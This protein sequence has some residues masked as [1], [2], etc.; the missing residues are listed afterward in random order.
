M[1]TSKAKLEAWRAHWRDPEWQAKISTLVEDQTNNPFTHSQL[2]YW[3]SLEVWD[4]EEGLQILSGVEPGTVKLDLDDEPFGGPR[5]ADH[6]WLN[7]EPFARYGFSMFPSPEGDEWIES[8]GS[9]DERE[10]RLREREFRETVLLRHSALY[11][12]L[13]HKLD[14][15]P[16]ALGEPVAEGRWRPVAFIT[17]AL[18]I[19]I[20]PDWYEWAQLN[21]LVP[22]T[23]DP[24]SAPFLDADA[25]DYPEL[26]AI[27]IRAWTAAKSMTDGTP[28]QRVLAYL[29]ARHPDLLPATK[30]AIA[31]VVNW[32]KAGGRP[33]RKG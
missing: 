12:S 20:K 3:L 9:D 5:L 10:R 7:A 18:R 2:R 26:L 31:L 27:A 25:A 13:E 28:K 29:G 11:R 32:Q 14:H 19:G 33:R 16:S 23:L 30:E 8:A 6:Q 22:D 1:A 21:G 17:W 4:R 15:S 24:M